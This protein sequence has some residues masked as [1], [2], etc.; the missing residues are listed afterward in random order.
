MLIF[1]LSKS[2]LK[3]RMDKV[4][5]QKDVSG[6]RTYV[7]KSVKNEDFNFKHTKVKRMINEDLSL[8]G[9]VKYLPCI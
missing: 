5:V 1:A 2:Y 3:N 4:K 9:T 7:D 6:R 8:Y